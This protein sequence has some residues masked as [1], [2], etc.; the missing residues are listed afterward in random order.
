MG[1]SAA[2]RR[3][4]VHRPAP[5]HAARRLRPLGPG[6]ARW[7][8]AVSELF[9]DS[10]VLRE[11]REKARLKFLFLGHG[12]TPRASR[13]SSSARLGFAPAPGVRRAIPPDDATATT[14]ASIRSSRRACATS[15][16]RCSGAGSPRMQ[17]R[18]VAELADRYGNGELRTTTM[19]NLVILDVPRANGRALRRS[20][21]RV[22]LPLDAV[23]LPARH[24][25]LHRHASSA[26]SRSPRRRA[27]PGGWWRS[28]RR[29]CPAST[30]TSCSTSPAAPTAAA[31][32][33]SPIIGIEGKK[34]E[35][36][37]RA[38]RR[39][40]LLRGRRRSVIRGDDRAPRR[41]PRPH[42]R[43]SRRRSSGLLRVY[44]DDRA[45]WPD[46]PGVLR[47]A[48]RRGSPGVPGRWRR[49]RRD[50]RRAGGEAAYG[51]DG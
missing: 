42:H 10:D 21:R 41:L 46:L 18:A 5:R 34:T 12:W 47:N 17:M 28:W 7:C 25:R 24:H 45:A 44:L 23:P 40:L 43:G 6:A 9:R 37:R 2:R 13:R 11:H 51:V 1:F 3:R 22:G 35:G 14:W 48:Q 8:A 33:G 19:Q 36:R 15:A 32:T 39:L 20:S 26:S 16:C 38:G 30:S 49:G 29:A 27:S 31:S 4:A 50:A